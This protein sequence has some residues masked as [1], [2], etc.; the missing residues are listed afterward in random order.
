[1]TVP[2]GAKLPDDPPCFRVRFAHNEVV[3][4]Q[5]L[6]HVQTL[7][8]KTQQAVFFDLVF[9]VGDQKHLDTGGH[10][11][12]RKNVK[13]PVILLH[14]RRTKADYD[15]AQH[16][17]RQNTTEQN[18]VLI[19]ARDREKA[20]DQRND[21]HIAHRRQL[22]RHEG[23]QILRGGCGIHLP[24]NKGREA[25][26]KRDI[27]HPEFQTFGDADFMIVLVQNAKVR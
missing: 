4:V 13:R 24:P 27:H 16:D 9:F 11:E 18:A 1:M 26:T 6:S 7:F 3:A 20:E 14:N 25:D 12:G 5:V 2:K 15:A 23:G 17:H 19:L 8:E 21:K 22:F 10:Q